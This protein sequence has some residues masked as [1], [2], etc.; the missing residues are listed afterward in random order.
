MKFIANF[1]PLL[2]VSELN[3]DDFYVLE[4]SVAAICLN[5]GNF[6]DYV[7]A[8]DGLTKHCVVS[9]KAKARGF[10]LHNVELRAR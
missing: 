5:G 8:I 3:C 6:L 1:M 2:H 4:R 7:K 9:I 10:I